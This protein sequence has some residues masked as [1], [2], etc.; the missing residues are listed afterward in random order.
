MLRLNM[1]WLILTCLLV[2][3]IYLNEIR[4]AFQF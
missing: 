4:V 1:A 3:G 2:V